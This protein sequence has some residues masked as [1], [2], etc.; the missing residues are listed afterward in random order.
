[1]GYINQE[2]GTYCLGAHEHYRVGNVMVNIRFEVGNGPEDTY[3]GMDDVEIIEDFLFDF[4]FHNINKAEDGIDEN[5]DPV[6]RFDV[7]GWLDVDLDGLDEDDMECEVRNAVDEMFSHTG[8]T[9]D[10][11]DYDADVYEEEPWY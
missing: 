8:G 5:G 11:I 3:H 6:R 4:E 7:D 1:M 9:W 10:I 2:D